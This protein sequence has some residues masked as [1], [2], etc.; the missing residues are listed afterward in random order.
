MRQKEDTKLTYAYL[1][2][3]SFFI[4]F[5]SIVHK[6]TKLLILT[7]I[8]SYQVLMSILTLLKNDLVNR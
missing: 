4:M 1:I 8:K 3:F 2:I 5:E 7:N 6:R